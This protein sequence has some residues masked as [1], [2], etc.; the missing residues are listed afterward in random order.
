MIKLAKIVLVAMFTVAFSV[1]SSFAGSLDF[2]FSFAA[3][4][5]YPNSGSGYVTGEVDGLTNNATTAATHVIVQSITDGAT[6]TTPL[7]IDFVPGALWV[8]N[9]L[10]TVTN[11]VIT[12]VSFE[13][14]D[15]AG[16]V[17]HLMSSSLN[18]FFPQ[19]YGDAGSLSNITFTPL[20]PSDVPEPASL[21]LLATSVFG[22]RLIRRRRA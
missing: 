5:G 14:S 7:P 13:A 11:G 20:T 1:N 8:A 9:N 12:F 3:I 18:G 21:A 15:Q 17:F 22:L 10:F 2:S 19:A 16:D 4:Q 6:L